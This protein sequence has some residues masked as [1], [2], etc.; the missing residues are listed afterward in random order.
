MITFGVNRR[1]AKTEL[2]RELKPYQL[3]F[4][5]FKHDWSLTL[6]SML[7]FNLLMALLPMAIMIFGILGLILGRHVDFQEKIKIKI[8]NSFPS[9]AKESLNEIGKTSKRELMF[10]I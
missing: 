6:A 9:K 7:A 2:E 4:Y 8:L 10:R 1:T 5:K 3:F